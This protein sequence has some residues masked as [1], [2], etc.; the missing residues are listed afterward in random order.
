M[1]TDWHVH[2]QWT[3]GSSLAQCSGKGTHHPKDANV[4]GVG[5]TRLLHPPLRTSRVVSEPWKW[6]EDERGTALRCQ[7]KVHVSS[8]A[9]WKGALRT[10]WVCAQETTSCPL[11]T[12]TSRRHPMRMWSSWLDAALASWS[13]SSLRESVPGG[14]ITTSAQ[15]EVVTTAATQWQHLTWTRALV[16]TSWMVSMTTVLTTT[17]TA[18]QEVEPVGAGT[19]PN[20]ILSSL[21]STG[22]RKLWQSCSLEGSL[23]WSLRTP[24]TPPAAQTRTGLGSA[25]HLSHVRCLIRSSRHIETPPVLRATPTCSLRRRW[26]KFWMTTR[27]F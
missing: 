1:V 6:R 9:S 19:N 10:M 11:M 25:H 22:R 4:V 15:L 23:T 16:M 5:W 7:V 20:W 13:W 26:P 14:T 8:A 27:S 18:G 3:R 21:A 17:I 12:S 2:D 24:A